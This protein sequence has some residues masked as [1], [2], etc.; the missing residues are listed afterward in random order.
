GELPAEYGKQPEE[1]PPDEWPNEKEEPSKRQ[2]KRDRRAARKGTVTAEEQQV[3]TQE[4]SATHLEEELT[5]ERLIDIIESDRFDDQEHGRPEA[6]DPEKDEAELGQE[7]SAAVYEV[8]QS[9]YG[10][11]I[12]RLHRLVA[13]DSLQRA[14]APEEFWLHVRDEIDSDSMH[15]DHYAYAVDYALM[16]GEID[17]REIAVPPGDPLSIIGIVMAEAEMIAASTPQLIPTEQTE[18]SDSVQRVFYGYYNVRI[19]RDDFQAVCDS[20]VGFS[21][22][23]TLHLHIDPVLWSDQN[24]V[25]SDVMILFTKDEQ[26]YKAEFYGSPF[27]SS[28]VDSL[29]NQFNQIKGKFMISWFRDNEIYKHDVLGNGQTYYYM[30]DDKTG[31][32]QGFMVCESAD[33][34][35]YIVERQIEDIIWRWEPD[36][37]IYPIDM[38]PP[39][40][41]QILPGFTWEAA[42][43]PRSKEEVH[44][45]FIR[46]RRREEVSALPLPTFP[47]TEKMDARKEELTRLNMWR[48]RN[49]TLAPHALEFIHDMELKYAENPEN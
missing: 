23:S 19:F 45:R 26:L 3:D 5:G 40:V 32:V 6:E 17:S 31:E 10:E 16:S 7:E 33:I 35:F 28:E 8:Y 25:V 24:Q 14:M 27:M 12:E 30:E 41:D 49:D 9:P 37:V 22:D 11:L 47:I 4:E 29:E 13:A 1:G 48:D 43:R 18:P 36:Y 38:I 2:Q 15:L 20:I 39:D 44:T 46:P 42:R 21:K 34:T